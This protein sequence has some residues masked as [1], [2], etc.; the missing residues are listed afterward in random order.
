MALSK[1]ISFMAKHFY[2]MEIRNL[3]ATL[4]ILALSLSV[5]TAVLLFPNSIKYLYF[6][7]TH[8]STLQLHRLLTGLFLTT[9]DINLILSLLTRYQTLVNLETNIL[10]TDAAPRN[11]IL[12]FCLTLVC[13]FLLSN[14]L[15]SVNTFHSS[16][17][18]ALIKLLCDITRDHVI[19]TFGVA[20]ESKYFPYLY[21]LYEM[22]ISGFMS[23]CYYGMVW[24]TLYA[25]FRRNKMV[26]I[27]AWFVYGVDYVEIVIRDLCQGRRRPIRRGRR[28]CD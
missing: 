19:V 10:V 2:P 4:T 21:F 15:E 5:P 28:L 14:L 22:V 13:P 20:I 23:K 26:R 18:M 27:P 1:I 7:H 12:F 25:Y 6:D 11:E 17:N 24:A 16:V 9:F 8:L 3:P